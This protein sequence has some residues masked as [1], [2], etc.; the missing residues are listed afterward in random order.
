MPETQAEMQAQALAEWV[1]EQNAFIIEQ[2]ATKRDLQELETRLKHALQETEL[3]LPLR[4]GV[5]LAPGIAIM[6]TLVQNL[7]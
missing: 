7:K 3:W 2:L 5:M 4:F 1:R 6:A